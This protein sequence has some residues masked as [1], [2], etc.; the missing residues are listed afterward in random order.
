MACARH[1]LPTETE[2]YMG[3]TGPMS[4]Q[5][6]IRNKKSAPESSSGADYILDYIS[7]VSTFFRWAKRGGNVPWE[8]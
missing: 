7:E 4:C 3:R 2:V 6:V 8:R 5:M 1:K